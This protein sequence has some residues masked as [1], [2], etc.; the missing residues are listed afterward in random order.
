M[1]N[2]VAIKFVALA[3]SS[4][5]SLILAAILGPQSYGVLGTLLLIQQYLSYAALGMREGV[6]IRL[7]QCP[8]DPNEIARV[9]ASALAWAAAVGG[10]VLLALSAGR[11]LVPDLAPYLPWV[12]AISLLS[13]SNEILINFNRDQHKLNKI[14]LLEVLYNSAPLLTALW[15]WHDVTMFAVLASLAAGL[16]ISVII[17]LVTLPRIRIAEVGSATVRALIRTGLPMAVL[18]AVTLLVNSI[19]V[20][21]ANW[22][23]LG[24]IVGLVVFGSNLCTIVLFGLNSIAWAATSRSMRSLYAGNAAAAERMRAERLRTLFRLGVVVAAP[25]CLASDGVFRH[26]MRAYSGAGMY[27]FYLCLFQAYGLL[28]FDEINRL[29]VTGRSAWVIVG[30]ALLLV[31]VFGTHFAFPG[32]TIETLAIAGIGGYF[33]LA[34]VTVW[35]GERHGWLVRHHDVSKWVFLSYPVVCA[36]LHVAIGAAGAALAGVG[37]ATLAL[38]SHRSLRKGATRP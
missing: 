1:L 12:G 30:N 19:Y 32:A 14:A 28:L 10:F 16:L 2:F 36:L 15:M 7:A 8:E 34:V 33:M 11:S 25:L 3:L 18:S 38:A 27:A 35:Y 23:A 6:T 5:R 31:L 37:Y 24:P 17:Y 26:V 21:M 29:T 13:I 22:M 4:I 20:V 9:R